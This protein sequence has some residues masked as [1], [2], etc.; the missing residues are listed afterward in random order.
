V[1]FILEIKI[2]SYGLL[3][4]GVLVA[5]PT[6]VAPVVDL[7]PEGAPSIWPMLFVVVACGAISGFHSLVSSGTSSK[8]CISELSSLPIGFGGML[9]EGMLAVFVL[10]ACGAGIGLGLNK[11]GEFEDQ[12]KRKV[13]GQILL[14]PNFEGSPEMLAFQQAAIG[15][16]K[17]IDENF[18]REFREIVEDEKAAREETD[19]VKKEGLELFV[20]LDKQALAAKGFNLAFSTVTEANRKLGE[21]L[22]FSQEGG[23]Q[24]ISFLAAEKGKGDK[25]PFY[26]EEGEEE[27]LG[28]VLSSP[29]FLELTHNTFGEPEAKAESDLQISAIL[30]RG[31]LKS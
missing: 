5:R 1:C 28:P 9:M 23:E 8:Q 13:V 25:I 4:I 29:D 30:N 12:N 18:D 22:G 24:V 31:Y 14:D 27:P 10:I 3:T 2:Q 6:M 26:L 7:N 20:A 21:L 11:G 15:N 16:F 19:P 17:K